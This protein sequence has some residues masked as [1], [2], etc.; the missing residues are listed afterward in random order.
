MAWGL[1][2][3]VGFISKERQQVGKEQCLVANT[4]KGRENLLNIAARLL[5]GSGQKGQGADAECAGNGAPD[6]DTYAE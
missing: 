2:W 5:N 1:D 6:H 4:G 3:I